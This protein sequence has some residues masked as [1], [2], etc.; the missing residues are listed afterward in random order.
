[1]FQNITQ[2]IKKKVILLI[3]SNGR[4]LQNYRAVKKLSSLLRIIRSKNNGDFY[5][6]NCLLSLRTKTNLSR[7]KEYAK[8]K[9]FVM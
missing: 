5:C 7:I 1:M 6:L 3:I 4:K 9:I 2:I 8:I